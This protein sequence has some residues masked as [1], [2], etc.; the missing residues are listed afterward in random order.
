MKKR[1]RKKNLEGR[2]AQLA[3]LAYRVNRE[4]RHSAF[5]RFSGHVNCVEAEIH[6]GGWETN[7][8][9]DFTDQV[10]LDNSDRPFHRLSRIRAK[11]NSLLKENSR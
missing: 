5:F 2:I 3:A 1:N 4:T 11:L 7:R 8:H 10:W 6:K 9:A